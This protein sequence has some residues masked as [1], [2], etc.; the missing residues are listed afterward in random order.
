WGLTIDAYDLQRRKRKVTL[1]QLIAGTLLY[2][3]LYLNPNTMQ[4]TDAKTAIQILLQQREQLKDSGMYKN[5]LSK[6]LGKYW[7]FIRK[8]WLQ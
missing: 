4:L 2:Y 3:P 5:W 8:F 7:Y 6:K 1:E